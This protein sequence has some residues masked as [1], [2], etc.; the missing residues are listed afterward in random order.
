VTTP[1]GG[2]DTAGPEPAAAAAVADGPVVPAPAGG[3]AAG[4]GQRRRWVGEAVVLAGYV[5]AGVVV[6]WPRARYLAGAL[7]AGNDQAQYVWNMWWIAH[8]LL[9]PGN[10]WF[11]SYLA[12]PVGIQLGYDVVMPLAGV[13]LAPVTLVFGPSASYS[14]LAIVTPGLACYTMYRLARL[15]LPGRAGPV[16]AGAFFG[17]SGMLAF[18]DWQHLPVAVGIV[19]LP[20]AMEA[21]IRLRRDPSIKRGVI[22]GVVCGASVLINQ[23]LAVLAVILAALLLLPWLTRQHGAVQIG[24]VAASAV[25]AAVISAPQLIAMAQETVTGGRVTPHMGDYARYTAQL[26]GLFALSPRLADSGVLRL[27]S[28][29]QAPAPGDALATFGVVLTVVAVLGLVVSW[30]RRGTRLLGLMW[31]GSALLS[32]G[33]TLPIAGHVLVPVAQRWHRLRV[34]LLM[35][36]T[37]FIHVPVLTSFREADR[38]A[39]IGLIAAAL[40]AGAAVVW[41]RQHASPAIIAV[42]VLGAMEAGWAGGPHPATMPT[43]LAAVDRPIAA[44][45]SGSVVVDVPFGIIGIPAAYG[46]VPAAPALVLATADG[47]PRAVSYGPLAVP[48]TVAKVKRHAFYAGLVAAMAGQPV[49]P[50]RFAA[51]R[52]D[53]RTLHIGWALVWLRQWVLL[54]HAYSR[55]YD[56][57]AVMAYLRQTGFHRAYQA[58]GVAV[59]RP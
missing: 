50:A 25:T 19:F 37:W 38:L 3:R 33:P 54:P 43:A 18:Q 59:Y 56:T 53:L 27:G 9:H 29:Y 42:V 15:W 22:L 17:L 51:A 32:L 1:H 20:L 2:M 58:D 11:T 31:L 24:A 49:S 57:G 36:Y 34:S 4:P 6:T 7:P 23:E 45:H 35:P 14:L 47:H 39:I 41:L 52:Q 26:P 40:L 13:L 28:I 44:D 21:A 5:T 8:Q 10:P 48:A 30:R 55:P 12:A 46:A 16:A